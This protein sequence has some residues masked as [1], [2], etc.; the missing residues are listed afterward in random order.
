MSKILLVE[1]EIDLAD[2]VQNWLSEEDFHLVETARDGL[3]GLELLKERTYDLAI[4]DIMLPG[5]DGISICQK[6]R[7]LGGAATILMLSA[8]TSLASKE[9]GLDSG[10]D[11]YLTK[12]FQLRELSARVR[13]LLR[14][15][16]TPR[17]EFAVGDLVLDRNAYTVR[18]GENVLNLLPKEFM[19]LEYFMRNSNCVIAVDTLIDRIWGSNSSITPETVRS[20]IK[21]LRKK[22]DT[23]GQPSVIS[24]I[25]GMGYKLEAD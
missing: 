6:Y 4:I 20:N 3:E 17:A 9:A 16:G 2:V 22:I 25:Y 23:P 19:L 8:R 11:D 7:Q 1:D 15:Q 10:A 5:L 24:N 12:P 13:A 18:K 14:R 21:S